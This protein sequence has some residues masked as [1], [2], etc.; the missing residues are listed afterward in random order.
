[1]NLQLI[2]LYYLSLSKNENNYVKKQYKKLRKQ[3]QND[4]KKSKKKNVWWGSKP[5]TINM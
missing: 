5:H 1:M 3:K 2:Y 4:H